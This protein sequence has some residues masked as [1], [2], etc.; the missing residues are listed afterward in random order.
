MSVFGRKK[1]TFVRTLRVLR[2]TAPLTA[3]A[4]FS[5]FL[6]PPPSFL[7]ASAPPAPPAPPFF[8]IADPVFSW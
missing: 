4:T 1:C 6:E 7:G 3:L 2:A 5:A 8:P